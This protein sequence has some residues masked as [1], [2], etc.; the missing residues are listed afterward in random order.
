MVIFSGIAITSIKEFNLCKVALAVSLITLLDLQ[1][2]KSVGADCEFRLSKSTIPMP[3]LL[4][5]NI[6][7]GNPNLQRQ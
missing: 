7:I 4:W 1:Y 6:G 5:L 2:I 3:T